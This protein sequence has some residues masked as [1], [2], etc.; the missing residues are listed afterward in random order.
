MFSINFRYTLRR[1]GRQKLNTALH[2]IGLTLGLTVC[3]LIGLFL[4]YELSFDGY[5][6]KADRT[7]RINQVWTMPGKDVRYYHDAPAPLADALRFEVPQL[8]VVAS[9][10][11]QGDRVVEVSPHKRF[12]Q[13]GILFAEAAILDIFDFE[14]LEGNGHE[15]LRK[16]W[17]ALLTTSLAKKYFGNEDP[18][19][20][21]F[22]YNNSHTITVAG[23]IKDPPPNTHLTATMLVSY[24]VDRNY[25]GF[26]PDQWGMT[27]GASTYVVLP[28]GE[29]TETL[30][31]SLATICDRNINKAY[32]EVEKASFELQPLRNIHLQPKYGGGSRWVQAV[33][34]YWLWFFGAI[35]LVVLALACINFINL[36]TAQALTRAKE[37]GVRKTIGANSGQLIGQFM[38]EAFL[39]ISISGLLAFFIAQISLPHMNTFLEKQISFEILQSP[40]VILGILASIFLVSVLTG[41]YP[42]WLT[43]STQPVAALK[44]GTKGG[45]KASPLLRKAL[46]VTQFTVS[47]ALIISLLFIGQQMELF[48]T[49]NM[50]FDKDNVVLL[51]IPDGDKR[52][53]LTD[54]LAGIRG[55]KSISLT[56]TMPSDL[57]HNGTSMHL[58]D[59]Q[60]PDVEK[61]KL[62]FADT[63]YPELFDLQL[64]AGRFYQAADTIALTQQEGTDR[65][66]PKVIVNEKLLQALGFPSNDV[67]IGQKFLVGWNSW[68]PEIV[69]VI[70]N[71]ITTSLREEVKPILIFE[72]PRFFYTAA[73][74]I[75]A[76]SDVPS[77]LSQIKSLWQQTFPTH[78]YDFRF[79][80]EQI[81]AYYEAESQLYALFKLF[82]MLALLISCL[83]LWGLATFA[84]AQKTKEIGIRKVLGASTFGIVGMLSKEFLLLIFIAFVLAAPLAYYFVAQWLQD[85]AYRI[86]LHWWVFA[87]AG[88]IA[89]AI[90][91]FVIS[92]QSFRAAWANPVHAL[93]SE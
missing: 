90:G 17:N 91:F 79:L 28:E 16:P 7:Y 67:A 27:F 36:A 69:G 53:V 63:E 10:Y 68:E 84:A 37:V 65:Q 93:R 76:N 89:I 85:F 59:L 5:H 73:I 25:L 24:I 9:I 92:F 2:I 78:I 6:E 41:W 30:E 22:L 43:S 55:V 39:L 82:S 70:E 50:G 45:K 49:Q 48:Y 38:G 15:A 56:S 13:D 4:H 1:L 64:K 61:V 11:P 88:V 33:S 18:I 14:V 57:D 72:Y 46:V 77:T 87:L 40:E 32:D 23:L 8:E 42:A 52:K 86:D 75:Q 66:S 80:D 12:N 51:S 20:K 35:G 31:A 19:G 47:C 3:L 62:I 81:T 44:S 26:N 21:T 71:F 83:G 54:G 34:P 29:S 60:S 58:T 74:K